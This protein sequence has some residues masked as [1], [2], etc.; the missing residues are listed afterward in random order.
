[1]SALFF[2]DLSTNAVRSARDFAQ[3]AAGMEL[4]FNWFYA[5]DRDI[6]QF[7][8][9]RLPVRPPTVDPGLP[10]KGDGE[11]EWRGFV[12]ASAHA[13]SINPRSGMILNWNNKPARGFAGSDSEWTWGPVQRVD[14]LWDAVQRR[15]KHTLGSAVGAVNL[16][17]TTDL[18][19]VRLVPLL[20][21]AMR[22]TAPPSTRAAAALQVLEDWR[23]VGSSRLDAD[24]DGWID[25]PGAAVLDAAWSRLA[26]AALGEVLGPL[27]DELGAVVSRDQPFNAGGSSF[28]EGWWSYI[29][30][31]LRTL[32][33]RPVRGPY[34][35]RFCGAGD[36]ATCSRA[37]WGALDAAAAELEA[38][39]G[40][41]PS[42]WRASALPERIRFAPGLMTET[43]RGTNRPTFQQAITFDGHRPR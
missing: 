21:E 23:S 13:Q 17:A 36:P 20:A 40:A 9:G 4:T 18:R 28:Y 6:A 39:Q 11:H 8:S 7:T 14:L 16:A 31:D 29:D 35:T 33:G 19:S 27:V 12:P 41:V 25:H 1:V 2:L 26:D 15:S 10:T 42:A 22:R 3:A 37:L 34:M 43:M 5:D 32:L 38:Q 30:K 24:L